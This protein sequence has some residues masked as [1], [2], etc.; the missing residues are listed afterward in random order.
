MM[1]GRRTGSSYFA[2]PAIFVCRL[3][4]RKTVVLIDSPPPS[5]SPR[6]VV[7]LTVGSL[8]RVAASIIELPGGLLAF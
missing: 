8:A 1:P 2:A 7:D 6:A 3:G 4:N 5:R